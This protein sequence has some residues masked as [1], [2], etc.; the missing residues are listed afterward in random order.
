MTEQ[1]GFRLDLDGSGCHGDVPD[2][3][4]AVDTSCDEGSRVH[5]DGAGKLSDVEVLKEADELAAVCGVET[6]ATIDKTP[7]HVL[8]VGW[9]N[10]KP[11]CT[12]AE[13]LLLFPRER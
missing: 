9:R 6:Y 5:E 2:G 10:V 12:R 13:E 7:F 8:F 1:R 11:K 3:D 4:C